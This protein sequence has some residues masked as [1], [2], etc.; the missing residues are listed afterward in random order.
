[1]QEN[2]DREE[3]WSRNASRGKKE[4]RRQSSCKRNAHRPLCPRD[5]EA[6]SNALGQYC[7]FDTTN[8]MAKGQA[9][10]H[11]Q[12][13]ISFLEKASKYLAEQQFTNTKDSDTGKASQSTQRGLPLL[14]G[15]HL[16]AVSLKGQ[17]RLPQE[18]KRGICKVCDTPLLESLSSDVVVE[19]HSTAA[20]KPWADVKV[21][22]CRTCGTMKRF[23]IGATRQDKKK[24]RLARAMAK[25][26][27]TVD[28]PDQST[29]E[30]TMVEDLNPT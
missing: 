17:M 1:M 26:S 2:E 27:S 11:V 8:T 18:M 10:K 22:T 14:L 15:S 28:V 3:N 24:V 5:L 7:Y 16:R 21:V 29:C 25:Q 6:Q 23:P 9:Q 30:S 19:N 4:L 13:R 12:A 20:S